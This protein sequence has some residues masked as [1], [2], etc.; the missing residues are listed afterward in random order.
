MQ[1]KNPHFEAKV[2]TTVHKFL[3]QPKTARD[4]NSTTC[5]SCGATIRQDDIECPYCDAD[6]ELTLH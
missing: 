1:N 2:I 5:T 3:E 6:G 4:D